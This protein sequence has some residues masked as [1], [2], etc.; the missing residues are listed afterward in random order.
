[1]AISFLDSEQSFWFGCL[2]QAVVPYTPV[3]KVKGRQQPRKGV[4]KIA[5]TGGAGGR[6]S[7][8]QTNKTK[9]RKPNQN[10]NR[11]QYRGG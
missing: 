10:Q 5:S 1:M 8:Q 6:E 11:R 4:R 2:V 9:Q 7:R 3:A